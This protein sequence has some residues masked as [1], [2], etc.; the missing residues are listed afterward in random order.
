VF[1]NGYLYYTE[2]T[3][4]IGIGQ[5]VSIGYGHIKRLNLENDR[6]ETLYNEEASRILKLVGSTIYFSRYNAE[7]K[8]VEQWQ[9]NVDG[10]NI[11]KGGIFR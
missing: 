10:T 11:K 9:M 6:T 4:N 1:S 7:Y 5:L 3:V 8:T 2:F